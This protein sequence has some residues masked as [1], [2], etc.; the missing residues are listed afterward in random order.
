M[1]VMSCPVNLVVVVVILAPAT[2]LQ[3]VDLLVSS[4]EPLLIC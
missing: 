4:P 3:V 1:A 2:P